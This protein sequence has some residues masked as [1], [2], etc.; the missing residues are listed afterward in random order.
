[1]AKAPKMSNI[2]KLKLSRQAILEA[3][4]KRLDGLNDGRAIVKNFSL[5]VDDFIITTWRECAYLIHENVDLVAIGG[6]GRS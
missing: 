2:D 4:E 5:S 3:C 6:F 1:M